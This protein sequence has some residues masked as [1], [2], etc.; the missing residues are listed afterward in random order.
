M[1]KGKKFE[2]AEKHFIKKEEKLRKVIKELQSKISE[3]SEKNQELEKALTNANE[4]L[5]L[6]RIENS[7][8]KDASS[9]SEDELKSLIER[10][11]QAKRVE[12]L[13]NFGSRLGS[14]YK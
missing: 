2:A 5:D 9:L 11:D 7:T 4:Q 6:L 12:A 10:A 1:P 3:L 13:L 14:L 8:L